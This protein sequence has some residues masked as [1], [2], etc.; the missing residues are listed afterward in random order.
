MAE[1]NTEREATIPCPNRGYVDDGN[2]ANEIDV[3][4]HNMDSTF[5]FYTMRQNRFGTL[6]GCIQ[7][8]ARQV[9]AGC[10]DRVVNVSGGSNNFTVIVET[11]LSKEQLYEKDWPL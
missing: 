11:A 3:I 4:Y 5:A 1:S 7:R 8:L 9:A 6:E 10:F 2:L